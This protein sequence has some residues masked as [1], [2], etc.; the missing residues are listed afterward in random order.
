MIKRLIL[1]KFMTAGIAG[2]AAVVALVPAGFSA[3]NAQRSG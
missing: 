2:L 1:A 3:Q